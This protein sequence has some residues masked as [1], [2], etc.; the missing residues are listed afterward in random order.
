MPTYTVHEPPL[1]KRE[2]SPNPERFVFVRDGFYFW[3]FLLG[4]IWMLAHRLWLVLIGY[5]AVSVAIAAGLHFAHATGGLRSVAMLAFAL[6]IG[7]EAATLLRFG[8]R[9][10][11]TVGLVSASN[12]EEAERRFFAGW[13]ERDAA[14]PVTLTAKVPASAE[15][16]SAVMRGAPQGSHV[17]GLFP[18][19]GGQR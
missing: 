7:F 19:P 3:A 5:M 9:K 1:K 2:T 17:L 18:E 15:P 10:W 14:T 11:R 8:Y 16:S 13:V 12:E 6:L 4:P